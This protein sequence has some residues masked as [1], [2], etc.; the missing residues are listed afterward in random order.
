MMHPKLRVLLL[1][2]PVPNNPALNVPL[3]AGY[4]KAYAAAQGLLEHVEIEILPR[5]LADHAGD[6]LLV[7]AIVARQP[8][9]LGL[10]LYTWNSER[11]LALA[12]RVKQRLPTLR[13]V[14]GG[15]EVQRD[16]AW[17]LR[18][19]AVDVAVLGEGEQTFADLLRLW[20]AIDPASAAA[21]A[22]LETIAGLAYRV[23]Q[24]LRF[25]AERIALDDLRAIPS[26]YL[27]GYLDVPPD[28][29][30]LVEVS[31]WCPYRCSFCLYGRNMGSRLGRRYFDLQ[32]LLDEIRWARARGVRRVHFVEANLNLVPLF[33]PLMEA[34]A[35]LNADRAMTFYA[36]LRA[37]HLSDA[38]V[39]AL[40]RANV[41][42]VEVGLQSANPSAL[43]AAQRPTNLQKWT[44][45]VRRLYERRIE[46]YLDVILG[47]PADD[48][49]GVRETIRFI[50]REGLGAYDVF[51]LQVLPGTAVRRQ[52][53]D[54]GLHFQARPPYYVLSTDRFS[55]AALRALRRE[56]KATAGL[57]PD[58]VEGMP[59]PRQTALSAALS[60]LPER[61]APVSHVRCVTPAACD[62]LAEL[63]PRLATQVD[64]VLP[65][66]WLERVTP[67]LTTWI[68]HNPSTLIDLY[69]L[70]DTSCPTPDALRRWREQLPFAPGY[71]DRVAVFRNSTPTPEYGR[72]S[73]RV[74]LV[75][76][77]TAQVDPSAYADCAAIV[78]RFDLERDSALP[79]GAWTAAGGSGI[80]LHLPSTLAPHARA[81][82]LAEARAWAADTGRM[83][84]PADPIDMVYWPTSS[85]EHHLTD[86]GIGV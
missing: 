52:A 60:A 18:H 72:V 57:D 37:E 75:L 11:S 19:P 14:V 85:G 27:L 24:E 22:A 58:A 84:W 59:L 20:S 41:R 23:G 34:L 48:E 39:A 1:Q 61:D 63:A 70:A 76:P 28:S 69:L 9:V 86:A 3:A 29:M 32:R 47:L 5:A 17:V 10:S 82:L 2:L 45:G 74:L 35:E 51:T 12:E 44:A 42:Y 38:H 77:W 64:L 62:A 6:A 67:A 4:L 33:W 56:L 78:W 49:V 50:T 73:P 26:P 83:L 13:V 65:A 31:R 7:E 79:L 8:Q 46:V 30:L 54:Y 36:E 71:L 15:P 43:R 21:C 55:F 16:N 40:D 66:A 80:W 53:A 81:A 68:A 25:T